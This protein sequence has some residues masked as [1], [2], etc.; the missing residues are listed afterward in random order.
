MCDEL[1]RRYRP[2]GRSGFSYGADGNV[3]DRATE[4]VARRTP[5]RD[6]AREQSSPN[7]LT[8]KQLRAIYAIATAQGISDTD[9]KAE[10]KSRFGVAPEYLTRHDASQFIEGLSERES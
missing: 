8:G 10:C 7:R 2:A 6:A 1:R 9:L 4:N 3:G 5:A